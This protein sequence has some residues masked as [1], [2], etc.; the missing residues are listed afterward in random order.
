MTHPASSRPWLG[1]AVWAALSGAA[2]VPGR[3]AGPEALDLAAVLGAREI[4]F[5]DGEWG[6]EDGRLRQSS[7]RGAAHAFFAGTAYSDVTLSFRFLVHPKGGGVRAA[8]AALR[9]ADSEAFYGVHLDTRND[10]VVLYVSPWRGLPDWIV[11]A[12]KGIALEDG[13]WHSARV[14][15]RGR[16]LAVAVDG[17][18]VLEVEDGRYTAGLVGLYTSEGSAA[19]EDVRVEGTAVKL[20][21]EWRDV[22]P[23]PRHQV[24]ASGE[25]AGG[26]AAFPDVCRTPA[27]DLLCVFYA[28][29]GHVSPPSAGLPLGG[30]VMAVRSSDGGRTWGPPAVVADTPHD[31]R[32]PHVA[33]LGG[34]LICNW[35]APSGGGKQLPGGRPVGIYLSRSGDGGK[36][37]S[38]PAALEIAPEGSREPRDWF[39]CSAPVREL[40]G[41]TWILGIY[42]EDAAAGR[43][44]GATVRSHDRGRTWRDLATIG[45]GTGL[46]LDAETDVLRLKD[47]R[48]L[49]ALRSSK[50]D[51][52]FATSTDSG[53]SWGEVR[54]S[55]FQGH[56]PH[57]LRCS[58]GVILLAH[59]IPATALHWSIDEGKSWQ[60][61]LVI[62]TVGGAY[63]SCVELPG[64][65]VYVVYYEEGESSSIRCAR[66][67]VTAKGVELAAGE[68]GPR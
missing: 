60:G 18:P 41:G 4:R 29:H 55:G 32:D 50:T 8:G 34:E 28:G 46:Y 19:F 14:E 54:S 10:Q 39:A 43:V 20:E 61:P 58:S 3:A 65:E 56:C 21:R 11:L 35:F 7:T 27:G 6:V 63:P 52:Y 64:G 31:D 15:A 17:K 30:R 33:C 23:A 51:L 24:V 68:G 45:E 57:F 1:A 12:R 42:T 37:W 5:A 38:E 53:V 25:A 47:G 9:S 49:A 67:R 16:K 13:R 62:D 40:P 26:Y 2:V 59:R 66:L 22:T 44:F 48:L 36:T